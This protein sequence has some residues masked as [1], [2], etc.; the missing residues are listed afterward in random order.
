MKTF[1]WRAHFTFENILFWTFEQILPAPKLFCSPTAM[2]QPHP[3]ANFFFLRKLV[4]FGQV[5]W[6]CAK[7]RENLGKFET[8]VGQKLD[9]HK[10][11]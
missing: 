8:K 5:G 2:I 9:F 1:F 10:Y 6:I 11:D 4:K 3:L 7:L